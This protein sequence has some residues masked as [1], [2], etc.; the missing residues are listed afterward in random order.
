M[1]RVF[2]HPLRRKKTV[3]SPAGMSSDTLFDE[4]FG[5]FGSVNTEYIQLTNRVSTRNAGIMVQALSFFSGHPMQLCETF[6]DGLRF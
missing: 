4:A 3:V 6:Q 1:S 5:P 2:R